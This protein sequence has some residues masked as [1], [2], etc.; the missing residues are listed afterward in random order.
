[1]KNHAVPG[2]L[3]TRLPNSCSCHRMCPAP[4]RS[5]VINQERQGSWGKALAPT[6]SFC[7]WPVGMKW[8]FTLLQHVPYILH[9]FAFWWRN[10][11]ML[12]GA[13][14]P[15]ELQMQAGNSSPNLRPW[16]SVLGFTFNSTG[17]CSRTRNRICP[18]IS[19]V[20]VSIMSPS[21]PSWRW[22]RVDQCRRS[23]AKNHKP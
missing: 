16:L 17:I 14:W 13:K 21:L 9:Y 5:N 20:F 10:Y 7:Y 19:H 3:T 22:C 15:L 23:I 8:C 11:H 4:G 12:K 18:Y 1:M 6:S 2:N